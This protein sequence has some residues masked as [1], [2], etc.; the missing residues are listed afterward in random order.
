[1]ARL[2]YLSIGDLILLFQ[3][4]D[5]RIDELCKKLEMTFPSTV[6]NKLVFHPAYSLEDIATLF[7]FLD[8][9]I[10]NLYNA[11]NFSDES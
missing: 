11:L 9:K 10:N 1:M 4:L 7:K 5:K 2:Y 8:V 3:Y 6:E